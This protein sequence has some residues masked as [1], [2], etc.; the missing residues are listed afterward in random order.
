MKLLTIVGARPQFIKAAAVGYAIEAA[1]AADAGIQSVL[2]HTGQHYD[3]AMSRVFFEELGLPA[4]DHDLNVGS[5]SHG[6]QTGRMLEAIE[7]VIEAERPN[8]VVV[9]G[10]TN[11]TLAGALAA[12]KLH[13][14]VAHV[15]AGLRSYNRRM[16]EEINRVLTDHISRWLFCPGP[17]AVT[18]LAQ[19]GIEKGVTVVGDVMYELVRRFG[20]DGELPDGWT[21]LGLR[22]NRF[23]LATIHRAENTDDDR[24]LRNILE[25]LTTIARDVPVVLPLHPRTRKILESAGQHLSSGISITS[26]LPYRQMMAAEGTAA[27]IVTDSG[28]V[29]KE[30]FWLGVPCVTAR[31][32]TEWLETRTDDRNII[33]GADRDDLVDAIR[34]QLSRGRLS[35][36]LVNHA[37][38]ASEI[39]RTL[40]SEVAVRTPLD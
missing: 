3:F 28:G 14:P 40:H 18:N 15:E 39:V 5:G 31:D 34:R 22:P 13:V 32:E 26:P 11:S 16:P 21:E 25:A 10:D 6:S 30:A 4:P 9:Y 12:V 2:V 1:N 20:A 23:V 17:A 24:R 38:A 36:P 35:V 7:R 19:E 27:V 33:A 37:S 8:V 29:Q